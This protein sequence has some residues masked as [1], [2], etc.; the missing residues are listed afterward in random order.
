[1]E[2]A[3]GLGLPSIFA[4]ATAHQV[5]SSDIE[6]EAVNMLA[7]S[8]KLNGLQ[9]IDVRVSD[10]ESPDQTIIPDTLLLSDIN[11]NPAQ[12]EK[13]EGM[14]L[15]HLDRQTT[16]VLST[17]QR[18]MAKPFIHLLLPYCKHSETIPIDINNAIIDISI[19]QLRK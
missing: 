2:L 10:W 3:A 7:Q 15:H 13:L 4:A 14:I 12:F 9:N 6:P 8:A 16:I 17:P 18:L 19:F 5:Y 1:M 11:Y